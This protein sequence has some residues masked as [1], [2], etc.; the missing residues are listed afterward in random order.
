MNFVSNVLRGVG[1][2]CCYAMDALIIQGFL[3]DM[4]LGYIVG[5]GSY[6]ISSFKGRNEWKS[7]ICIIKVV[8]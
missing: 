1:I 8:C 3:D 6:S 4:V 5:G 7:I 2:L